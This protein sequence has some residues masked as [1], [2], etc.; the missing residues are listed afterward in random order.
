[1]KGL[2]ERLAEQAAAS[3]PDDTNSLHLRDYYQ[4]VLDSVGSVVYTVDRDLRITGANRQWDTFA[5]S[6]G[7]PHLTR[8]HIFG[9]SLLDQMEGA[10]LERWRTICAQILNGEI[11]RYLDEVGSEQPYEWRHFSLNATP[12][13]NSQ[14]EIMGITFVASNITQ[15]KKAEYEMYQRIV[16]IRGLQQVAQATSGWADRRRV[17]KQVTADIA[18]LFDAEKCVIFLWDENSGNLQAQEPAYGLAGRKLADL[19]LDMGHPADPDSLWLDLE[20]KDY[21]LLNE[22]DEAPAD[23]VEASAQVDRLA[24]VLGILR[25]SGRIHGAILVA[26]RPVP[27]TSQDGELLALFAVPTA[28]SIENSE[29]N[30]RLLDR[31][32]QL[33]ITRD[34]MNRVIK[35]HQAAR[36]PLGVIRGYLEVMLG[37]TLGPLSDE[38]HE[39]LRML[40]DR[41]RSIVRLIVH[42]STLRLPTDAERSEKVYLGD[43]VRAAL[44]KRQAKIQETELQLTT[45]LPAPRDEASTIMGDPDMLLRVF[46]GLLDNAIKFNRPLGTIEVSLQISSG[47][48]RIAIADTGIGISPERLGRIWRDTRISQIPNPTGLTEIKRIV[49][50]HGGQVWAESRLGE[51]STFHVVLGRPTGSMNASN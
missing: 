45:H 22:G 20:Q 26:G 2:R 19:S 27:F 21:I 48:V 30:R 8:R 43:L 36:M 18:R 34:E 51:G 9:S 47:I 50:G 6:H 10:P 28:L 3:Q 1:M 14:N 44:N 41:T 11:P 13:R 29:L 37:G 25:V 23:M 38:Q 35:A 15:L 42:T 16:Q 17:Y 46:E 32:Q 49:E 5:L 4:S 31:S 40:L 24:A 12:L 33:A 7:S 39:A